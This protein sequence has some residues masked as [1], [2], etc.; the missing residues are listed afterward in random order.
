MTEHLHHDLPIV[1]QADI[2][3]LELDE[4][5]QQIDDPY[6]AARWHKLHDENPVYARKMLKLAFEE[7]AKTPEMQPHI[8]HVAYL[9]YEILKLAFENRATESDQNP[10]SPLIV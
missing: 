3:Q 5:L 2:L 4:F 6:M 8:L 1:T 7:S 9:S 10:D